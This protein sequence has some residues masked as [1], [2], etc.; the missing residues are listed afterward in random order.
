MHTHTGK[1]KPWKLEQLAP[2][3]VHFLQ[4]EHSGVRYTAL[5]VI[6]ELKYAAL[7]Q[8]TSA[9]VGMLSD[10]DND[11]RLAAIQLLAQLK[12][13][14]I[15]AHAAT[16]VQR[17]EDPDADVRPAAAAPPR[18]R[19]HGCLQLTRACAPVHAHGAPAPRRCG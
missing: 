16:V 19:A 17:L 7:E 10:A 15:V 1:L 14:A 13:D 8:Q 18:A 9:V 12:R 2:R 11:V 4:S 3:V 5:E 6:S